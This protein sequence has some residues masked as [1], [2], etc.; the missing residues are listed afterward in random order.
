D[1]GAIEAL[2]QVKVFYCDPCRS[3]QKGA[4]ERANREMRRILPKGYS[5]Q[6]LEQEDV[7]R[8]S[9]HL[10]SYSCPC[11]GNKSP[12]EIY[13]MSFTEQPLRALEIEKIPP[14]EIIL[15]PK[16]MGGKVTRKD[17]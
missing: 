7:I 3:D 8:L 11:L 17:S 6:N 5:L 13:S 1:P 16:L 2:G 15:N 12:Y 10:N 14:K 9:S 4:V